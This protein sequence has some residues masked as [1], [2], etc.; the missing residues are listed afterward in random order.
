MS[1]T[2]AA[3]VVGVLL[4]VLGVVMVVAVVR[5][6]RGV[7]VYRTRSAVDAYARSSHYGDLA[8]AAAT[9]RAG[10]PVALTV[11]AVGA[12]L[13]VFALLGERA[14]PSWPFWP[15]PLGVTVLCAAWIVVEREL[16]FPGVLVP[17]GA[18][19]TAGL[20]RARRRSASRG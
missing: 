2:T 7:G 11:L 13:V 18:R 14:A 12:D 15:V 19:G 5:N 17:P 9:V 1:P 10:F 4:L 8:R 3:W 16:A 6:A 20:L